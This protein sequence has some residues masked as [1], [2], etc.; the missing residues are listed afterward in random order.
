MLR[1][2]FAFFRASPSLSQGQASAVADRLSWRVFRGH[3]SRW[4]RAR[5]S[6]RYARRCCAQPTPHACA[7]PARSPRIPR[8]LS[9]RRRGA[10]E[11]VASLGTSRRFSQPH[12]RRSTRSVARRS[13]SATVVG[14]PSMDFATND[15]ARAR[16]SSG[17]RPRP[18]LGGGTKASRQIVSSTWINRSSASVSGSSSSRIQGNRAVWIRF[19][20]AIVLSCGSAILLPMRGRRIHQPRRFAQCRIETG[21]GKQIYLLVILLNYTLSV[22]AHFLKS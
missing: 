6:R 16:R 5:R 20:R 3:R 1:P 11:N 12:I 17:L 4:H 21:R 19:H 14:R 18:P 15:R 2:L 22:P 8:S 10:R 9:L 13:I 7:P